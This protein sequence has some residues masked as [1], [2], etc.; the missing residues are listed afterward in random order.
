LAPAVG[1]VAADAAV[2]EELAVRAEYRLAAERAIAPHAV[3]VDALD[4]EVV[5]RQARLEPSPVGRPARRVGADRRPLPARPADHRVA[6]RPQLLVARG[7]RHAML[8]VGL[9]VEVG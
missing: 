2:A 3:R 1:G 5:E 8:R 6:G 7:V 4:L 9:P